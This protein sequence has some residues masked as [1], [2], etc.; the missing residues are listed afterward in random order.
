MS[1]ECAPIGSRG[2]RCLRVA[3]TIVMVAPAIAAVAALAGRRWSPTFDLAIIDLRVRDVFTARTPLTG[4]YSRPGWNH[5]GPLL[6]YG[7]APLSWLSGH[8]TWATRVGGAMLEAIALVWLAVVTARTS[9]RLLLAAGVVTSFTYLA[10]NQWLF[11]E[12]WNLHVPIPYFVLFVFVAYLAAVGRFRQLVGMSV[13]G[14]LLVQT[15][16]GYAPLVFAGFGYVALCTIVDTRNRRPLPDRWR[17]VVLIC[18]AIWV[19]TWIAPIADGAGS[20]AGEPR[21]DRPLLHQR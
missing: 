4:L 1:G 11:H 21:R 14:T 12:P 8:A 19:V 3:L 17:Q 20:L 5:P 18:V 10:S 2:H 13:V 9:L 16:V 15:H 6:F 7:I